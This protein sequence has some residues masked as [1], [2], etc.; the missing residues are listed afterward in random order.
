ME[1]SNPRRQ[2]KTLLQELKENIL[3]IIEE[4]GCQKVNIIAHSKGG[5]ESRYAITHLGLSSCVASL[6]TINTPIGAAPL[7]IGCWKKCL[8][9]LQMAGK[10]L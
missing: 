8:P 6:T 5:L 2:P 7:W 1:D 3:R 9:R 4:S 10:Q